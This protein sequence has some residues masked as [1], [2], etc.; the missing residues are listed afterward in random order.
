MSRCVVEYDHSS[1]F[2][3]NYS[4]KKTVPQPGRAAE[5]NKLFVSF[6]FANAR[7]LP[8]A[9]KEKRSAAPRKL[10]ERY[11]TVSVFIFALL[12]GLDITSSIILIDT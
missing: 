12:F 7:P 8:R 4:S 6:P 9:K 3:A 5:G 11:N 2:A 1:S 10:V